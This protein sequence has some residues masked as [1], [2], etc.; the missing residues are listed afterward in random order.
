MHFDCCRKITLKSLEKFPACWKL[1]NVK[2]KKKYWNIGFHTCDVVNCGKE[3]VLGLCPHFW[4]RAPKILEF[5]K[6]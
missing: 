5:P 6:C 2:K 1:I 4:H 3:Y